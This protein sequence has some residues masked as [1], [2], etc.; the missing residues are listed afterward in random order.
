M[1]VM[2]ITDS[3]VFTVVTTSDAAKAQSEFDS[4]VWCAEHADTPFR[5]LM[6]D[7][8]TGEVIALV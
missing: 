5:V 3:R 2:I 7:T 6:V 4:A 8:A 1:A